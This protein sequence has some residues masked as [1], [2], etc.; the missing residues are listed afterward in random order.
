MI[1]VQTYLFH[2]LNELTA[3][4]LFKACGSGG[5]FIVA[6]GAKLLAYS[7]AVS[8]GIVDCQL[9]D[10]NARVNVRIRAPSPGKR[11]V[12]CTDGGFC[13]D[14]RL[15]SGRLGHCDVSVTAV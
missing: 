11:D 12:A 5:G 4:A 10:E 7:Q 14:G 9:L 15:K 8:Q 6:W 3:A 1:R 2:P 13:L